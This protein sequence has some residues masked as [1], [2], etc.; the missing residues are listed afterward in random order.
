V[1]L[2]QVPQRD[3]CTLPSK[4]FSVL[5][6]TQKICASHEVKC[7]GAELKAYLECVQERHRQGVCCAAVP[8]LMHTG[9]SPFPDIYSFWEADSVMDQS[10]NEVC[11]SRH[12]MDYTLT[13]NRMIKKYYMKIIKMASAFESWPRGFFFLWYWK[14]AK[15]SQHFSKII[16]KYCI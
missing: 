11:T 5:W 1:L 3:P 9:S 7:A 10:D 15:F 8:I 2:G 16:V 4:P 6:N 12:V 13:K 14:L